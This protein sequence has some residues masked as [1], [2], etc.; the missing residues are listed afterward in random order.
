VWRNLRRVARNTTPLQV[1]IRRVWIWTVK[2]KA[3]VFVPS[4]SFCGR[5]VR[6]M[7][8]FVLI[9]QHQIRMVKSEPH[10]TGRV[11]FTRI[12]HKFEA[13]YVAIKCKSPSHIED[14]NQ[15]CHPADF[16]RHYE[17][18]PAKFGKVQS[19][20]TARQIKTIS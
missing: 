16:Y 3:G 14:L 10:P 19:Q 2:V 13:E 20:E 6:H 4:G 17:I 1:L 15:R 5:G 9:V 7:T 12:G 11:T 8:G 18:L